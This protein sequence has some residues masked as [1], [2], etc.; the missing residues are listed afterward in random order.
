MNKYK[1]AI[2]MRT[3]L[4]MGKGKM[5]VQVG[6]A[7]VMAFNNG[8]HEHLKGDWLKQG[9][10]D[11]YTLNLHWLEEGQFKIVCKV[12]AEVRLIGLATLARA[13]GLPV[14]EV[15]DFGKTQVDP[16]TL[17]C[18]AIGPALIEEVD[19]ITKDLKLL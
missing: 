5:C 10:E 19:K 11:P 14:V 9:R 1:L 16:D 6:H 18:I 13:E 17:T 7:S 12:D 2:I 4:E 15:H 3:D 8:L